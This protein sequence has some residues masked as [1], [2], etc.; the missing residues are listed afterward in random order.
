MDSKV[1]RPGQTVT[2]TGDG[3]SDPHAG[4]VAGHSLVTLRLK[5]RN[6]RVIRENVDVNGRKI[7]TSVRMPADMA[8]GYYVLLGT[9]TKADGTNSA[10]SP[11][12]FAFRIAGAASQSAAASPWSSMQSGPP[13][14]SASVAGDGGINGQTLLVGG[15][16][17]LTL[18]AAGSVLVR[19]KNQTMTLGV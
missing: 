12:R 9:Q 6:G 4:S 8:P 10:G 1:M 18:L 11:A 2:V 16:L 17:S 13:S 14:N 3:F 19:R 7:S 15:I 5:A